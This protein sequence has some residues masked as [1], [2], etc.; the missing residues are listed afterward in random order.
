MVP[1]DVVRTVS[2]MQPPSPSYQT[3]HSRDGRQRSSLAAI[4]DLIVI[5][6]QGLPYVTRATRV[7]V[8]VVDIMGDVRLSF[9]LFLTAQLSNNKTRLGSFSQDRFS[10]T[11]KKRVCFLHHISFD[12][13]STNLPYCLNSPPLYFNFNPQ[14]A[15][16]KYLPRT[17][18]RTHKR[19]QS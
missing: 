17:K 8:I 14:N 6:M 1:R 5:L 9:I 18:T 12:S 10:V 13:D 19:F 4:V 16:S 7:S 11:G 15:P 3:L 2:N